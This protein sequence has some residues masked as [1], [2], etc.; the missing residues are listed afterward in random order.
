M[1][2]SIW[3]RLLP[4][5]GCLVLLVLPLLVGARLAPS[6]AS[7]V[8]VAQISRQPFRPLSA[9]RDLDPRKIALGE[10]LFADP[11]L[12]S[13]R[14]LSCSSCHDL[15]SGGTI[16]LARTVGYEGRRHRFN[17]PSIFNVAENYR[18][19]WRGEFATLQQENEKALLDPNLMATSW[20]VVIGRLRADRTYFGMFAEAFRRPPDRLAVLDALSTYQRSLVTPNSDFDRYLNGDTSALND[21]Q[22]RGYQLFRDYGCASCHQG[23]N[24]GGNMLQKFGIYAPAPATKPEHDVDSERTGVIEPPEKAGMFRVPSLRNVA[25]TAPYFHDGRT[26]SLSE[27]VTIMGESQLGKTLNQA[28]V[29]SLVAFL[30]TL[31]GEYDGKKLEAGPM[32]NAR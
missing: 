24:L 27:A 12:S 7:E 14:R 11:I 20:Q 3:L 5:F 10:A 22:L 23:V 2:P 29:R 6:A 28:D 8:P 9:P 19:G 26:D 21:E 1:L 15:K 25:V 18:L 13:K 30:T 31:T 32:S 16:H 17:A 4:S